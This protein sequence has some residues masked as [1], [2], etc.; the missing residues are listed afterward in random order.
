MEAAPTCFGGSSDTPAGVEIRGAAPD[1]ASASHSPQKPPGAAEVC[2]L[3]AASDTRRW[4]IACT[5]PWTC[6]IQKIVRSNRGHVW[7]IRRI[8]TRYWIIGA[9]SKGRRKYTIEIRTLKHDES[10]LGKTI[11]E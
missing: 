4:L 3:V 5:V 10:M 7:R 2:L 1:W 11:R 8:D 6:A 9:E